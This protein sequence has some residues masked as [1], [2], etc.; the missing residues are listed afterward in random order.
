MLIELLRRAA[1]EVPDQPVVVTHDA[2]LSYADCLHRAETLACGLDARSVTRF[3]C[4]VDDVGELIALLC[5]ASATG[6]EACVY[7]DRLGEADLH[8][9]AE[10]FEHE[11]VVTDRDLAPDGP[12]E[13][14]EID[15]LAG[16]GAEPP[17]QQAA[18]PV[19][20]LTTGTTGRPK[21]VRHDWRR[22]V[23]SVR[24]PD[25]RPGARWLLAYNLNQFAG[26]QI[27]LHV[28]VSRA[29]LVVGASRQPRDAVRAMRE[30]GVTHASATPTFW[31]L[32]SSLIGEDDGNELALEQITLGGEA[33]PGPLLERLTQRFPAVR[34][35]QV[36]A[37]NE[38]GSAVSVRDGR[39][40]LP[41]SVLDRGDDAEVQFRI[42]DGEL[43][44][45]SRVGMLGYLGENDSG[46]GWR[47]TGDLVEVRGDR[48]HF[49][50]RSS[51]IINVGGV[52]VH[53]LPVEEAVHAV[54]GVEIARAYGRANPVA[55]Q[56]VA[57]DVVAQADQDT[58]RLGA[59]IRA[60][61]DALPPAA[62]PR[63]IRF[64]ESLEMRDTKL[65]R[66]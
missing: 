4:L 49:V 56:I 12:P 36:Y 23:A 64:V 2:A 52:K 1:E 29:T 59:A 15:A 25:E 27:L 55:G 38:F 50:G 42:V 40:G 20:I 17:A 39:S 13:P 57:V 18:A 28:V 63:R 16:D 32:A 35:S 30:L 34:I 65:A 21:G 19:L 43:H 37:A 44:A 33:V 9:F 11:L 31:R 3:A 61:C 58:E 26:I 66:S 8:E 14:L 7:P 22:L 47:P 53:P 62:R 10:P 48:I 54:E 45:R 51:E 46:D 41:L 60:A 6:V 24:H 5:A